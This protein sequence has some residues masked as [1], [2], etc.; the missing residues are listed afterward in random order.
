M[1]ARDTIR[2]ATLQTCCII[3][4]LPHE[5]TTPQRLTIDLELTCDL[6]QAGAS[7]ALADTVDYAALAQEAEVI[8]R[9]SQCRLLERLA[10][11][12][13]NHCLL[14]PLVAAVAV[15]LEKPDALP[16]SAIA[17]VTITRKRTDKEA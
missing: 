13:A 8:A 14:H 2:L 7:D 3:G 15:Q 6:R 4:T 5:R 10:T 16:G 12:L 11:L 1:I 17:S 9:D